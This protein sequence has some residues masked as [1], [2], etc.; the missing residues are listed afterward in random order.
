MAS[1]TDSLR[2]AR[3]PRSAK[4]FASRYCG[5]TVLRLARDPRSAK[6]RLN[7]MP[8]RGRLRLARDPRSAKFLP[9]AHPCGNGCGWP[10]IPDLLNSVSARARSAGS[11]R[12]ARDPR[13]AKFSKTLPPLARLLR[14]AR[15]PRSA[16]FKKPPHLMRVQGCG[17]PA[18]P[19]L[20][21]FIEFINS[22]VSVAVGPRSP[23]C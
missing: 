20:L 19:D 14:L 2:L 7:L 16:K 1:A 17:W 9:L 22:T 15:D 13:S 6:F 8:K 21:N 10:A 23:I 5:A 12:L 11:L 3:D 18:I 4:F